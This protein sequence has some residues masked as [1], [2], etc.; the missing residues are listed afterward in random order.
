MPRVC[1]VL[2]T[3]N[4]RAWL[5]RAVESVFRQTYTDWELRIV[6]DGSTDGSEALLAEFERHPN[7]I[8]HRQANQGVS[9]ARNAA[10]FAT[11]AEWIACLD[12]DDEWL[13]EK[14]ARQ[15]ALAEQNPLLRLI[16]TEEIWRRNG[17]DVRQ[18]KKYQKSGGRIF[19]RCLPVCCISP[20]TV[21]IKTDLMKQ[22]GGFRE[23]F[24]VCEDY[25]LWLKITAQEE[26]GFLPDPMIIKHGGHD[27]QLSFQY[28]AMDEYRVRALWDIRN[29]SHLQPEE[30]LA[31]FKELIKKSE[32]LIKGYRKYEK[33]D[34]ANRMSKLYSEACDQVHHLKIANSVADL[35]PRSETIG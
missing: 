14:L 22:L 21:M 23:D 17:E 35:P 15:I 11:Q 3:Y 29:N 6:D 26:A 2:P 1:V 33:H 16:H 7:V 10:I 34:E 30:R 19:L 24:V 32:I 31:V 13:P 8:V 12:S 25:D 28:R 9:R 27:D 5:A 18:P 4:R 20:S